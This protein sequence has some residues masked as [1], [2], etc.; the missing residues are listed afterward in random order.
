M[1]EYDTEIMTAAQCRRTEAI[2][3]ACYLWPHAVPDRQWQLA[4]WIITGRW[5]A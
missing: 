2:A 1:V 5:A 4:Q 3:L